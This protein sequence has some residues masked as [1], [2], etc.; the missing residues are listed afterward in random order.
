[1]D[2][3][4]WNPGFGNFKEKNLQNELEMMKWKNSG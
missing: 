1:M 2:L 3:N 4:K